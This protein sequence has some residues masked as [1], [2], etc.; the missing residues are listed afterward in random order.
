[1][2]FSTLLTNVVNFNQF[3]LRV[4][5]DSQY[6]LYVNNSL[7]LT[8]THFLRSLQ[9]SSVF[10]FLANLEIVKTFCFYSTSKTFVSILFLF[11]SHLWNALVVSEQKIFIKIKA[12]L[13]LECKH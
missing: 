8:L 10:H 5:L 3:D 6:T 12:I 13:I 7:T 9:R 4:A 11:F 1:M 2:I